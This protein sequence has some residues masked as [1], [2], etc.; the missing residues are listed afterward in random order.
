MV[1][2]ADDLGAWLVAVLAD[3]GRRQLA[4]L[5]F[6]GEQQRALRRAATSAVQHTAQELRPDD[7]SQADGLALVISQVFGEQVRASPQAMRRCLRSFRRR[8][9]GS[10]P[11]LMTR[12]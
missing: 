3:A 11:C 5:V 8:S 7:S 6:G 2:V 9:P 10:W 12:T 4:T 1:F